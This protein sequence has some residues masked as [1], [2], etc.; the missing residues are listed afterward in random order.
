[1]NQ[2]TPLLGVSKR[3][4]LAAL[5]RTSAAANSTQPTDN[6]PPTTSNSVTGPSNAALYYCCIFLKTLH[7]DRTFTIRTDHRNLLFIHE[8][9]NPMIVRWCGLARARWERRT[10]RKAGMLR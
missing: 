9:S 5:R 2:E 8:N 7:R 4:K 6:N 10:E 3:M 1:M